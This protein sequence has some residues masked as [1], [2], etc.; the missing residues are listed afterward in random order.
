MCLK[1]VDGVLGSGALLCSQQ[2]EAGKNV[3]CCHVNT[4]KHPVL[5]LRPTVS[6]AGSECLSDLMDSGLSFI[7]PSWTLWPSLSSNERPKHWSDTQRGVFA[8]VWR[9][10]LR[11]QSFGFVDSLS[12]CGFFQQFCGPRRDEW[13]TVCSSFPLSLTTRRLWT[14]CGLQKEN[15][16]DHWTNE[17]RFSLGWKSGL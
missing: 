10:C 16:T 4:S 2:T 7:F 1:F 6:H 9:P 8:V 17:G 3:Q 11:Q 5:T 12:A 13:T 15:Q 14:N